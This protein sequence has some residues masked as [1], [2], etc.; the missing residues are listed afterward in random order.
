MIYTYPQSLE[1]FHTDYKMKQAIAKGNLYRIEK[2]IYSD[3]Q[4]V[5][6]LA[7]ITAKYPDTI[8]TMNTA[9]YYHG[10]TDDVPQKYC[11]CTV[12]SS[13]ELRDPRIIQYYEDPSL[14]R[15]GSV[16]MTVRDA[17]FNIYDKERMLIELLRHRNSLPF[18][19][20]K[21]V[22]G[23]YRNKIFEL[24]VERIQ[25]YAE[26]FP[27]GKKISQLLEMEVF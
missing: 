3:S 16:R 11:I 24:D 5:S 9:L 19:F 7:V 25:E 8:I 15:L 20:Y 10:L 26:I 17:E 12:R 21:E 27:K 13:R 22:I 2:G 14:F 6:D 23:N 4:N 1:K 18:D